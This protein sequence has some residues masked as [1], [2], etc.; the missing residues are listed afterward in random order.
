MIF[1][2]TSHLLKLYVEEPESASV[3]QWIGDRKVVVSDLAFTEAH[4]AVRRRQREG[5]LSAR[6]CTALLRAFADDW[7]RLARVAVSEPVLA[8][9]AELLARHPLRSLDALQL[10]SAKLVAESAP[11]PVRFGSGDHRLLAAA[12]AEGLEIRGDR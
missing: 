4:A 8:L 12:T 9:S 3:R 10:A 2:D 7:T 6:Q 1:L 5:T 11:A